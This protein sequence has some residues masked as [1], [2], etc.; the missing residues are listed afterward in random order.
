MDQSTFAGLKGSAALLMS[1]ADQEA[2]RFESMVID[3]EHLLIG[4]AQMF[5]YKP[6]CEF[7]KEQGF[8][9]YSICIEIQHLEHAKATTPVKNHPLTDDVQNVIGEAGTE[10]EKFKRFHRSNI[11]LPEH[12]L[13]SALRVP[14]TNVWRIL[15]RRKI[16]PHALRRKFIHYLR[17]HQDWYIPS[18]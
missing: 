14:H 17:Y 5:Q 12:I 4:F 1:F 7:L 3:T 11:I 13:L 6:T 8:D 2:G 9:L 16:D 18:T 10:W 15:A